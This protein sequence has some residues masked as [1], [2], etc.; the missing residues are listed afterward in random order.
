[1]NAF[2]CPEN[3]IKPKTLDWGIE[4]RA[5]PLQKVRNDFRH[6]RGPRMTI[7]EADAN[8][9]WLESRSVRGAGDE[10][11]TDEWEEDRTSD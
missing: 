8:R 2:E 11:R 5:C 9:F 3:F 10:M 6:G 7:L 4:Q 1:M